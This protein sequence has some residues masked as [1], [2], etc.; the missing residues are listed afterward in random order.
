MRLAKPFFQL[1]VLFDVERL[2]AEVEALPPE[3]WVSHP[4]G[5]P[6]NSAVRL[7]SADGVETDSVHGQMVE[8][9][10]LSAMPTREQE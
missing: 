2:Q 8:T 3:A 7:I 4:D 1:P 9:Q 6:G 5:L 10:W